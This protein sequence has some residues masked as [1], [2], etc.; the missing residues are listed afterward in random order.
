[1]KILVTGGGGF[2]GTHICRLLKEKGHEVVS[3][4]RHHYNHLDDIAVPTIKGDLR[5][6]QSVENALAGSHAVFHVAAL[7]GIW[8][9]EE[10]YFGINTLGTQNMVNACKKHGIKYFIYTSTPS[11]VFEYG[12]IENGDESLPYPSKFLT[13]YAKSKALAEQYVLA[14][15]DSHFFPLAIRPHLI[16][17][18]NDPHI[19]P[20]LV[21]K[22]RSGK[23]KQIGEGNNLVDVIYVE[24]AALAHVQA[25]EKLLSDQTL[26]GNAYFIGQERPVNLWQFINDIL[27]HA[28]VDLVEDKVSFKLAYNLGFLFEIIFKLF[29]IIRP[30]PPLTRFVAT[31][32]AKSHYFSHQKAHDH[33]GHTP[34]IS[35]EEGLVKTFQVRHENLK[36]VPRT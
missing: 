29:G 30:E 36:K 4:S 24:N 7:A 9:K 17:G 27:S 15:T 2:L 18:P 28:K 13:H 21:D 35:I 11:V 3:F 23:L 33:F 32:M 14:A 20:R 19:I 31:Q 34:L 25:F 5:D 1:M 8:G 10:S 16:F 26:A 12:D 6:Y 22:A